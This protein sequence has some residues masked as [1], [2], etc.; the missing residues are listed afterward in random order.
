M[1]GMDDPISQYDP[2]V[3]LNFLTTAPEGPYF[4]RRGTVAELAVF[5][6]KGERAV[7]NNLDMMIT[8]GI[9]VRR[10]EKIRDRNAQY[11]FNA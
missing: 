6:Q 11:A 4:E 7:R 3:T 1:G 8:K 9:V 10:S 5:C 2:K